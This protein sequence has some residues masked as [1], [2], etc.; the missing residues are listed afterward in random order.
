MRSHAMHLLEWAKNFKS[1]TPNVGEDS[2]QQE[3]VR[4]QNA[5]T[6]EDSLAVSYKGKHTLTVRSISAHTKI[7]HTNVYSCFIHNCQKLE[8][9]K[10]FFNK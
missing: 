7:L 5:T 3:L 2:E 9:T 1:M 10:I 6:L 8:A 4:M